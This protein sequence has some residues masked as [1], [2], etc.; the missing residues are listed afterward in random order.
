MNVLFDAGMVIGPVIGYIYQYKL[1]RSKQ[2]VG[3]FS[4][5]VCGILLFANITRLNFYIFK[6][7]EPALFLQSLLMIMVQVCSLL[8]SCCY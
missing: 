8:F 3:T 5:D 2:S 4:I 6:K 1:I 7:Y